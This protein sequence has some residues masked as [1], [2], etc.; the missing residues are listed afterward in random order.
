MLPILRS[1]CCLAFSA[2]LL[3]TISPSAGPNLWQNAPRTTQSSMDN[4][5]VYF[6][7]GTG[8]PIADFV[9]Y[10]FTFIGEPSLLATVHDAS[11]VSYRLTCVNCRGPH[12]LV[13]RL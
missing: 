11:S 8:G 2:A 3:T 9:S 10:Y 1:L 13:V 4:A 12:L 5:T 6:P 7:K